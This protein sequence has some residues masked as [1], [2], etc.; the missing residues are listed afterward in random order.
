MALISKQVYNTCFDLKAS[1]VEVKASIQV[2][3]Q[4]RNRKLVVAHLNAIK[5]S[6][7]YHVMR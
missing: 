2:Q 7:F 1:G 5:S 3:C 4:K 6:N